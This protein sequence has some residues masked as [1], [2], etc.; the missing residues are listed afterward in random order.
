[1]YLLQ[2]FLLN[3]VV[4]ELIVLFDLAKMQI[5]FAFVSSSHRKWVFLTFKMMLIKHFESL[6][7]W[8]LRGNTITHAI[9]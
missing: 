8:R 2:L 5:M 6:Y 4:P 7:C 9:K 3:S 1:M